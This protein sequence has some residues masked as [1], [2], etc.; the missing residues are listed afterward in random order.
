MGCKMD[1]GALL[2]LVARREAEMVKTEAK[3]GKISNDNIAVFISSSGHWDF[4]SSC[5]YNEIREHDDLL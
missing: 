5:D 4:A 1:N 3:N 2:L